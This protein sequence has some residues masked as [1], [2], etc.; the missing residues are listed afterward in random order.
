MSTDPY[1]INK[2]KEQSEKD[3]LLNQSTTNL[4]PLPPR[5]TLSEKDEPEPDQQDSDSDTDSDSDWKESMRAKLNANRLLLERSIAND[6]V[7]M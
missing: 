3:L 4:V 5:T 2:I 6:R 1:L 7:I